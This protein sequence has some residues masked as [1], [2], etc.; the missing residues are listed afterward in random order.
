VVD[1]ATAKDL[2][3]RYS[4]D[5]E[6]IADL[7]DVLSIETARSGGAT[8]EATSVLRTLPGSARRR[9]PLR[10]RVSPGRLIAAVALLAVAVAV[11]LV[12]ALHNTHHGTGRAAGLTPPPSLQNVSLHRDAAHDYDPYGTGGEHPQDAP[13]V[14]DRDPSSTWSTEN[15]EAGDLQKP[16]VGIYVDARPSV[17]AKAMRIQT[18][19]PGFDVEIYA[20]K[21]GPPKQ[22]PDPGWK[23]V[24]GTKGLKSRQQISLDTAGQRFRY[25]LVWITKLPPGATKVQI[26]EIALFR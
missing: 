1:R 8:G 15:Y 17:S 4:D 7:E 14:V 20:A 9:L 23:L 2:P 25:Y 10:T 18:P 13:S 19:T 5:L 24:G 3:R 22:L 26:S 11:V 16:G 21:N 12:F 6:L